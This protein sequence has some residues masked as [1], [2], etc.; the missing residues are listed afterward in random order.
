[1][2]FLPGIF[3]KAATQ[4]VVQQSPVNANGSGGPAS[5]QQQ[6]ANGQISPQAQ[7]QQ[8]SPQTPAGGPQPPVTSPLD[9]FT[10]YFKPQPRDPKAPQ[11]PTL[12]DPYLTP[13]DPTA[14]KQQVAQANFTSNIPQG[15]MQ[16]AMSG[17]ATAFQEAINSAARE[18]FSAAAQLSHGLAEQATRT[19]LERFDGALDGRI[20]NYSVRTQNVSNE[21]LNH[22]AV[23]PMLN[24]VKAQIAQSNPNL[25]PMEIQTQAEQYFDQ[26]SNVLQGSKQQNTPAPAGSR[27]TDFSSYLA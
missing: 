22:P 5:Q 14:F 18:A 25:S 8:Q 27:E 9:Q 11:V 20:K 21:A 1:M 16:K 12:R 17:D 10:A 13:L 7:A 24:A 19:G 3:G 23:A 6:P 4:P 26:M 2:A 15:V